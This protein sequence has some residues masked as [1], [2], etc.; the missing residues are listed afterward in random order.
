MDTEPEWLDVELHD[1]DWEI[2]FLID[3]EFNLADLQEFGVP[4]ELDMGGPRA[5]VL[6]APNSN[7]GF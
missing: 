6:P 3:A 1:V 2:D 7:D 5:G 4:A